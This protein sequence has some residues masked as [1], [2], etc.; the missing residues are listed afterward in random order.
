L[1]KIRDNKHVYWSGQFG[2]TLNGQGVY[3]KPLQKPLSIWL[4]VGGTPQSFVRA[5]MLGLS[6]MVAIIGGQTQSFRPLIDLYREAWRQGGESSQNQI[7]QF[8][9]GIIH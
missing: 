1:L 2:P 5:G 8:Q 3:P 4:G 9:V 6:L 7:H